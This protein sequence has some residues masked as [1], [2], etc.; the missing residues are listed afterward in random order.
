MK[1]CKVARNITDRIP[2]DPRISGP[3]IVEKRDISPP[4]SLHQITPAAGRDLARLLQSKKALRPD[5]AT[6]RVVPIKQQTQYL[7]AVIT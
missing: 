1:P 3:R 5:T 7:P 2:Q 4:V 6:P